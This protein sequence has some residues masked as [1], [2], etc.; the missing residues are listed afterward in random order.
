MKVDIE[1]PVYSRRNG[2]Q[3]GWDP[4]YVLRTHVNKSGQILIEGNAPGLISLARHLLSLAQVDVP[5]FLDI[6]YDDLTELQSGSN[7]LV[8]QKIE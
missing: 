4:G 1:I 5:P 8:I 3:T 6:H 7:D 2:I